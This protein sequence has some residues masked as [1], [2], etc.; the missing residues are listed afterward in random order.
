MIPMAAPGAM[1]LGATMIATSASGMAALRSTRTLVTS[2]SLWP[3]RAT[4]TLEPTACLRA[5]TTSLCRLAAF[6][7]HLNHVLWRACVTATTPGTSHPLLHHFTHEIRWATLWAT[8]A[9]EAGSSTLPRLERALFHLRDALIRRFPAFFLFG[10][11]SAFP[12]LGTLLQFG[13]ATGG[14]LTLVMV[15]PGLLAVIAIAVPAVRAIIISHQGGR[16]RPDEK[17]GR[18]AE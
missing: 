2:T 14:N 6:L 13:H 9:T 12:C 7:P 8:A 17:G 18:H 15:A 11:G 3:P 1:P 10:G 5:T 16:H 4:E